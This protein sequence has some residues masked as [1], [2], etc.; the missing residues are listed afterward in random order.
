MRRIVNSTYVTLDGVIESPQDWPSTGGFSEDGNAVQAEL[1]KACDAVL[2]GRRTYHVF[3]PVWISLAGDPVADRMNAMPKY[4]VSSTLKDPE[5]QNT[6]VVDSDPVA[7]VTELKAQPGADIVQYGFG[8]LAHALMEV[9]LL[10]EL[11]LWV[12]P[13]FIGARSSDDL[14]NRAGSSGRFAL[15][16]TLTLKNGI[17]I[18]RYRSAA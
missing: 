7:A 17:V 14:L 4:V 12:H 18:L 3:A 15:N 6:I 16:E 1:L 5:W 10:D 9:G 13:F 8:P 11:H 2:M